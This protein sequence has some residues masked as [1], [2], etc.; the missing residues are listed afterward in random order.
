M[1]IGFSA[2]FLVFFFFSNFHTIVRLHELGGLLIF[3]GMN[4]RSISWR[5]WSQFFFTSFS[6]VLVGWVPIP[7]ISS[8]GLLEENK[9]RWEEHNDKRERM[10]RP[11]I[12]SYFLDVEIIRSLLSSFPNGT[13]RQIWLVM[14]ITCCVESASSGLFY[15]VWVFWCCVIYWQ[16]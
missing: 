6:W 1:D 16:R 8:H 2:Q 3:M 14:E 9:L 15:V 10:G 5:I 12:T 13:I 7:F 4:N 11:W